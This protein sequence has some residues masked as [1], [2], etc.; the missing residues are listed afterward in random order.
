[1][2]IVK[3]LGKYLSPSL[4]KRPFPLPVTAQ[5]LLTLPQESSSWGAA[6]AGG[7]GPE[8]SSA[9]PFPGDLFRP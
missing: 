8:R 7:L 9:G 3:W 1:M 4:H 2:C 5:Q 6:R